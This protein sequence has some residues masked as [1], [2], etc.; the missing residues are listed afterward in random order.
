ML[1]IIKNN[2]LYIIVVNITTFYGKKILWLVVV[3]ISWWMVGSIV[4]M[5]YIGTPYVLFLDV[6]CSDVTFCS[7]QIRPTDYREEIRQIFLTP[8]DRLTFGLLSIESLWFR[9]T[10]LLLGGSRAIR[11]LGKLCKTWNTIILELFWSS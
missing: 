7:I 6:Y 2:S 10:D 5:L 4:I 9:L 11:P 3:T 8:S 1:K